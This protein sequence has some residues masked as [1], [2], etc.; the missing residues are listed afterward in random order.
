MSVPME[1]RIGTASGLGAVSDSPKEEESFAAA[2]Y[3]AAPFDTRAAVIPASRSTDVEEA[4]VL[5]VRAHLRPAEL[6]DSRV[7]A[8]LRTAPL[9]VSRVPAA[10]RNR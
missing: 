9:P 6:V 4:L 5:D 8:L 7:Y 10:A 2:D 3:G 1:L